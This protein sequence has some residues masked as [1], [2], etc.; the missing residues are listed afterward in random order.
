MGVSSAPDD[1]VFSVI[2]DEPEGKVLRN[3]RM[4]EFTSENLHKLYFQVT[5][6]RTFLGVEV[7]TFED[8]LRIF[9][10]EGPHGEIIPKGLCLVV[11]DFVGIFWLTDIVGLHE[12]SV[13]YTFF[14]RR[15][16]GRQEL[17]RAALN[18]AFSVFKFHRLW[19]K[20]P[21]NAVGV[22]FFIEQIGFTKVGRLRRSTYFRGK[23]YDT[24][25][26]DLLHEEILDG[27]INRTDNG[28]R[29]E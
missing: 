10:D 13:H 3:V 16:K 14:D 20:V 6:F 15:H 11:D 9:V 29:S 4:F 1:I 8:M 19:T 23:Y 18:H 21:V 24:N 26:Y 5:K 25:V 22:L 2:C 28:Q 17:C 12:A 27:N 7:R